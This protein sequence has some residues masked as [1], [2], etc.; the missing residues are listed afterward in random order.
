MALLAQNLHKP[1]DK[2]WPNMLLRKDMTHATRLSAHRHNVELLKLVANVEDLLTI[3]LSPDR[4]TP[5]ETVRAF[6]AG[7]QELVLA[8]SQLRIYSRV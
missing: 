5:Y 3:S 8:E 4:Q 6:S 7:R 1:G 2:H